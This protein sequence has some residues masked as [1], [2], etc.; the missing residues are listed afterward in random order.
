MTEEQK[1]VRMRSDHLSLGL[2]SLGA[3]KSIFDRKGKQEYLLDSAS[4]PLLRLGLHDRLVE[5]LTCS[6]DG[7]AGEVILSF[8]GNRDAHV[9]VHEHKAYIS[10]KLTALTGGAVTH[11]VWGGYATTISDI[12]GETIGVVRNGQFAFGLQALNIHTIGGRPEAFP[13]TGDAAETGICIENGSEVRA[14]SADRDGGVLH[15][16][17]ALF[18][19]PADQTLETIGQIEIDE[20]LP[21]P[22]LD[23]EWSKTGARAKGSYLI[24]SFGEDSIDEA[25][26]YADLAGFSYLY[27]EDPFQNWGH[28]DLRSS[29]FPSGDSGL[30]A[31][32]RRAAESAM[33]IGVHTLSNFITTND[34][35]VAPVPDRRL[36]KTGQS[37]LVDSVSADSME[38]VVN[39]PLA[40]ENRGTL[41]S[42]TV[43]DEMIRYRAVSTDPPWRLLGCRRGAFGTTPVAHHADAT[44]EK[45]CDHPYRVLF[46]DLSMQDEMADRLV[47]LFNTTGVRQISFDGLEGCERT[48]HGMY[49]LN[50]F[51]QR[52]FDG[53]Q[54]EVL[55]DASRLTHYLWHIHTRMNWGEPWGKATRQGQIEQRLVN[56]TYFERNLFPRMFGWFQLRLASEGLEATSLDDMEWV[57]SKCAGYDSGFALSASLDALNGNGQTTAVLGAVRTWEDAR[58]AGAFSKDQ[59]MRLR[60]PE[61]D[62]HLETDGDDRWR[63]CPVQF[64]ETFSYQEVTLQPG[65]PG[66]AEWIFDNAY[67]SQNLSFVLRVLPDVG[68]SV[69]EDSVAPIFEVNFE[70]LAV[71]ITLKPYEYL[72]CEGEGDLVVCDL[73]WRPIR[74]AQRPDRWPRIVTGANQILFW[75]G[76]K[77]TCRVEIRFK[78]S[79]PWESVG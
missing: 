29:D 2:D 70:Q 53:W 1:T 36:M 19:C 23:G 24:T 63:L 57:L 8:A 52:C 46:P 49:S 22:I 27:H 79:G 9:T 42:V 21:H 58:L 26:R 48:G 72:V 18:G 44:V 61:N 31:C 75:F 41:A 64:S 45:L 16:S 38:L 51:V 74:L 77:T 69:S 25:V 40:F 17:I 14:F 3:I 10:F 30:A 11:V 47:E 33:R 76:A 7:A 54:P 4:N 78:A 73:N 43:G 34:K 68:T 65:E 55:N 28:F 6:Y 66:E 32:V 56:Q 15:S 50:R 20:G 37:T 12:V 71:P 59:T 60:N 62:F 67:D 13:G 5:P 35:Y 39:D